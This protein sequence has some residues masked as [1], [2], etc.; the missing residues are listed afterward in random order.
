LSTKHISHAWVPP[1]QQQSVVT[2]ICSKEG[3]EERGRRKRDRRDR[4]KKGGEKRMR[5]NQVRSTVST[6]SNKLGN[7]AHTALMLTL[8]QAVH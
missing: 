6:A 8:K 7:L 5:V 1:S 2:T 3:I 4:G